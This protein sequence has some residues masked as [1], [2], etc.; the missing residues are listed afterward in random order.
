MQQPSPLKYF[1]LSL[2]LSSDSDVLEII[3]TI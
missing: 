3:P 2:S 1:T